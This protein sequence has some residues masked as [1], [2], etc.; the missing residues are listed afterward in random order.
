[1][2]YLRQSTFREE[3]ISLE[4][5]ETAGREYAAQQGYTVVGMESD[6]GLS[7]RTFNRPGVAAVM[8][9]VESGTADVIILWKW[10]RL[11][12][13]RLDWYL[14]ADRAQ[15]A[16]GRIESATEPIDTST[17]IGRLARGMMI[18]IAAFESERAGDQWKEAQ[19]RRVRQGLPH[20][21]RVRFGYVYNAEQ[22]MYV[23]DPV[24]GPVFADLYRR[25]TAGE[26]FYSL[27][28]WLNTQ[29]IPTA[30]GS[31]IWTAGNLRQIMDREF[32]VGKVHYLGQV[33]PGAHEPL[34]TE[35]EHAAYR[36]ARK[37][38]AAAPRSEA[39]E[40]LLAGLVYCG[41]CGRKLTGASARG[42]WFYYRCYSSRFTGKHS[43]VQ[44]PA[45]AVET[46]VH[47]KL[48]ETAA[49]ITTLAVPETPTITVDTATLKRAIQQHKTSLG[50]LAVQLAEGI[51][52]A[53]AYSAAAPALEQKLAT[54][55]EALEAATAEQVVP[56]MHDAVVSL[57]ADWHILPT[58]HRRALLARAVEK[59]VVD[60]NDERSIDVTMKPGVRAGAS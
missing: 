28:I 8:D 11:S 39:S 26:T 35:A 6:P 48:I 59:V 15:E 1:M 32:A 23:P 43:Y 19:A 4:L 34:I 2:I 36:Q 18:E 54:A 16:G 21:G 44:A 50:R 37:K 42:R 52:S 3:S 17:S 55:R 53:D 5:Q 47:E 24:T 46:A 45:P 41:V 56:P 33:H 25:F 12:R 31:N 14:A 58:S 29:G 27:C 10:S 9:A 57:V 38:R 60:F 22:K 49:H 40:Y 30:T 7:G 51:I 20:D 13:N